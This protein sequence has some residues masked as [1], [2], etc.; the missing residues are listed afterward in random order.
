M[1]LYSENLFTPEEAKINEER[2]EKLIEL[3]KSKEAIVVIGAGAS[4]SAGC[5]TW[6]GLIKELEKTAKESGE[7]FTLREFND[8]AE[9]ADSLPYLDYA[10]KIKEHIAKSDIGRYYKRLQEIFESHRYNDLHKKIVKLPFCGI[11]TT[12]YDKFLEGA[13]AE[14]YFEQSGDDPQKKN[15]SYSSDNSLIID[16]TS[17][18]LVGNFCMSLNN[19]SKLQRKIAHLHGRYDQPKSIILSLQDYCTN[20]KIN[21]DHV[22]SSEIQTIH[23]KFLWSLFAFRPAVFI[24]FSMS[25]PFINFLLKMVCKD[26]WRWGNELSYVIMDINNENK[27]KMIR[28][29]EILRKDFGMGVVFYDN[30]DNSYSGL[31]SLLDELLVR[32]SE[33]A[34]QIT[35]PAKSAEIPN[36]PHPA[37]RTFTEWT[38][39]I[40]SKMIKR[41]DKDEN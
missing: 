5:P 25:D 8:S 27:T 13:L 40:N 16:E 4:V 1:N 15:F 7:G 10:D 11:V 32:T 35:T 36:E 14:H 3:I 34:M 22:P 9:P 2:K 17:A 21:L 23:A 37:N 6:N 41:V 19:Y 24:G 38:K 29:S 26:L 30:S 20:Y 12:N 31:E 33:K 28:H 39:K 18:Y